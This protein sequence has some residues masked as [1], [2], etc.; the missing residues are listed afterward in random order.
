[1]K[2]LWLW[3]LM[4]SI[5]VLNI[6]MMVGIGLY[7]RNGGPKHINWYIGYRT[8]RSMKNLETWKFAHKY[9]GNILIIA[10]CSLAPLSIIA[11]LPL[12]GKEIDVIAA[13]GAAICIVQTLPF[14]ESLIF[15]ERA[16]R[17]TFDVNGR[18]LV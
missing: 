9:C 1:M 15:T 16:L 10:G 17:R 11:M 4:L 14:I 5:N 7:F 13:Y 18:R 3:V 12:F 8:N 2:G 6:I